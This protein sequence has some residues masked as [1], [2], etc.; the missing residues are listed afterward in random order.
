MVQSMKADSAT[1]RKLK[2]LILSRGLPQA[3]LSYLQRMPQQG[4]RIVVETD[5]L[6]E[7]LSKPAL[8]YVLRL[9]AGVCM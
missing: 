6:K 3:A 9:L 8:P 2:D 7:F 4:A 1:G 5:E